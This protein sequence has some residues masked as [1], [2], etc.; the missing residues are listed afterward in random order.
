MSAGQ[1][2]PEFGKTPVQ[3][4]VLCESVLFDTVP[5]TKPTSTAGALREKQS[6]KFRNFKQSQGV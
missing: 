3:E 1:P 5:G 6:S 2:E 4:A